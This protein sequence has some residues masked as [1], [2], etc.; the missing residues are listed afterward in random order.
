MSEPRVLDADGHVMEPMSAFAAFDFPF[1]A[2]YTAL[3]PLKLRSCD[4]LAD[5]IP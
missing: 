2:T 3:A 5:Q 1:E 4:G